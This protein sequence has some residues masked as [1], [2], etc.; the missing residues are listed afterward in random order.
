[1]RPLLTSAALLLFSALSASATI[2]IYEGPAP[3][4]VYGTGGNQ[5][6]NRAYLIL[7]TT[8]S[9]VQLVNFYAPKGRRD[10]MVEAPIPVHSGTIPGV[11]GSSTVAT[12][13]LSVEPQPTDFGTVVVSFRGRN[14][15][16][17]KSV[18][19]I[20][21]RVLSGIYRRTSKNLTEVTHIEQRFTLRFSKTITDAANRS[22]ETLEEA[23]RRVEMVLENR[24]F[25]EAR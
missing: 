14:R 13:T 9:Q 6:K 11:K 7:D 25:T 8:T 19:G 2:L 5:K 4:K 22:E 1:M 24:R 10:F 15:D 17:G 12:G 21:P 20:Y 18:P 3:T 16:L 23:V